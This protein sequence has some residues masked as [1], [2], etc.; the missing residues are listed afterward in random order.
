MAIVFALSTIV[1]YVVLC[2]Y[3]TAGLKRVNLGAVR[4][5]WRS[6]EWRFHRASGRCVLALASRV[7]ERH[8]VQIIGAK[9]SGGARKSR[10]LQSGHH[11]L[12]HA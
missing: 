7:A 5:L 3:S 10:N 6:L 12:K 4:A 9:V 8:T 2:V 1:T 11:P